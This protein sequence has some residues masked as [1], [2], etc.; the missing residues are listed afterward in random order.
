MAVYRNSSRYVFASGGILADR[1]PAEKPNY[2]Q[3]IAQDGDSFESL[4]SKVLGDGKRYWE[5]ADM[6][7]Q[8]KWPDEIPSG[9][10]LRLPL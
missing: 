4:A 6:N 7:P 2:Y 1:K 10:V 3:Y 8:V 9:T 5:I